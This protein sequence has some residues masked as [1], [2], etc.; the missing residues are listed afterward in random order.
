MNTLQDHLILYDDACPMCKAYTGTFTRLG[1]LTQRIAFSRADEEI[2]GKIDLDRG[3]HEI[4]L[5]N[6]KTGTSIY[7]LDALLLIIGTR[8]PVLRPLFMN[9]IFRSFWKQIYWVITYNRRIIAGSKAPKVGMDC[10][11]DR[12][13]GYRWAYILLMLG[14]SLSLISTPLLSNPQIFPTTIGAAITLILPLL[15]GLILKNDRLSWLENWVTV[16]FI[17]TLGIHFLPTVPLT[18]VGMTA[19]SLLM[20]WKRW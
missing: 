11:P 3:R 17:F 6:P 20:F 4:P 15:V 2:L 12:H 5:Y 18:W 10:A 19:G 9:K 16:L 8:F 7:G 14:L 1:W 13:L